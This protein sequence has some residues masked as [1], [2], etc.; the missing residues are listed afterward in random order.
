MLQTAYRTALAADDA[1][2]AELRL[3]FG[4]RAGDFRYTARGVSTPTLRA[5]YEAKR[6]ADD[7]FFTRPVE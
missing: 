2:S 7:A 4:G 1:W 5:L 3:M 6:A